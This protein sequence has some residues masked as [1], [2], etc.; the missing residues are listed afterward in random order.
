[1]E[2]KDLIPTWAELAKGV[3]E[4]AVDIG[5]AAVKSL[6]TMPHEGLSSHE[7]TDAVDIE[8]RPGPTAPG[9]DH[10]PKGW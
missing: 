9:F 6:F 10:R 1:M 3:A 7:I 2:A 8:I 5:K 4:Y